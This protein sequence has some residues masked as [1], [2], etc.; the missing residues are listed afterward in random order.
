M[1]QL[2]CHFKSYY[3]PVPDERSDVEGDVE[4]DAILES[5]LSSESS[6]AVDYRSP[7]PKHEFLNYLAT[8]HNLLLHGSS[9]PDIDVVEPWSDATD[10][11]NAQKAVYAA[12]DGVM[13]IFFAVTNR[14][15][16]NLVRDI[17]RVSVTTDDAPARHFY[18]ILITPTPN[19]T[20]ACS[21]GM[22]YVLPRGPFRP[23]HDREGRSLSEWVSQRPVRPLARLPV[24]PDDLPY[25]VKGWL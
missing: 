24:G 1:D 22:V 16:P 15:E 8:C 14:A 9:A 12:S 5:A 10:G 2:P 6:D 18:H 19:A 11:W 4:F 13:P 17:H 7:R 20:P 23:Y 25:G 3:V 21:R